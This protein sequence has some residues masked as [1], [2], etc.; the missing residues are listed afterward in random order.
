LGSG[1]SK[2]PPSGLKQTTILFAIST[3]SVPNSWQVYMP[4]ISVRV[5]LT[6]M[7]VFPHVKMQRAFASV[8]DTCKPMQSMQMIRPLR[9]LVRARQTMPR[10][11]R[12]DPRRLRQFTTGAA[13]WWLLKPPFRQ[14]TA[15]QE[16][17]DQSWHFQN[18]TRFANRSEVISP[19]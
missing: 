3:P 14:A 9:A 1:I 15:N 16:C 6:D 10:F 8:G 2:Q 13:M 11:E 4:L 7:G 19:R 5:G 18:S 12:L 17:G